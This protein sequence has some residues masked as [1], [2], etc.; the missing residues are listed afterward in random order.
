MKNNIIAK[1]AK[2]ASDLYAEALKRCQV[3]HVKEV[4]PKDWIPTLAGKQA[5]MHCLAEFYQA[6]VCKDSKSYGEEI[7]RL[8]VSIRTV[9]EPKYWYRVN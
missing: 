1:L 9:K 7:A 2:T 4:L 8:M 6:M 3:P 5:Y